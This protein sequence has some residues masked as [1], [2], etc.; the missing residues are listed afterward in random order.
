MTAASSPWMNGSC[1]RNHATVDRILDKILEDE[2][3]IG[4]QKAVD[5]ACF[6]KNTEMNKTGFSPL[7][8]FCGKNPAF[9]GLSDC[10]PSSIELEGNNQ[11]LSV[12]RRLDN[13]RV[14]ARR[15]DC[16]QRMKVALK[17]QI[18]RSC[19]RT[20]TLGSPIYFKLDSAKKWKSGIV[21]GMDGKVLFVK[22]GN[23]IRRVP[24]DRVVPAEQYYDTPEDEADPD[25]KE[26][27]E[28][29]HD[30]EFKNLEVITKQ[31]KEIEQ[32]NKINKEQ[33]RMIEEVSNKSN[34]TKSD[35]STEK[36]I[37]KNLPNLYQK[38]R[39]QEAGN[40]V[41]LDGKVVHKHKPK[42]IHRNVV[43]L[44]LAD[45]SLKQFDFGKEIATWS[46]GLKEFESKSNETFATKLTKAQVTGRPDGAFAIKQEI[47]KFQDFSAFKVV[48]DEGQN[49]IRTRWVFTDHED[50]Q[51]KGYKIKARLCL[52]GD[53]ENDV[54]LVRSDS[55]TTHKDSLKLAL[56]IAANESWKIMTADIK[57]AFLQGKPLNR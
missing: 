23:F 4:L 5:L 32:L 31:K 30:D 45:G 53:T 25:D 8:L 37:E 6:V 57:S 2:P 20:Y 40:D 44:K 11:Y 21:L 56:S 38:I 33:E 35:D 39:F 42:S 15:V 22:Y 34:N 48:K 28:R 26:N 50:D 29:L 19:E 10:T 9:P 1:E 51:S 7:Q 43:V 27:D 3:K 13:A 54:E 12:L 17:S 55:P 47:K 18:N 14:E 49:A 36:S 24:V 16:N 52:R 46:D 41:F